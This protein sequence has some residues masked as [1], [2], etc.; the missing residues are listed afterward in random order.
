MVSASTALIPYTNV[1]V[2]GIYRGLV[3]DTNAGPVTGGLFTGDSGSGNRIELQAGA[4]FAYGVFSVKPVFRMRAPIED[5]TGSRSI[6]SGSPFY[7]G[8][9]NRRAMEAEAV[10]TYDPE[11]ATYFFDWDNSDKEGSK[12]AFSLSVLYTFFADKTDLLPYK[13]SDGG[14]IQR[15]DGTWAT[16]DRWA[17]YNSMPLQNNLWQVGA[18]LVG[19]PTNNI[20]L[21]ASVN[22][23][24]LAPS[25]AYYGDPDDITF[26][27]TNLAVRYKKFIASG[28]LLVNGWGSEGWMRDQNWTYPLQYAL[29]FAYGFKK[30]SF[31]DSKNRIGLRMVG[32]TYNNYSQDAYGALP[33]AYH[34]PNASLEGAKYMEVTA[35][36]NI[37][38]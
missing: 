27:G 36:L 1:Y 33:Y 37:G 7:V 30:P 23:G 24:H 10:F 13:T 35:Y 4:D 21:I 20:R 18:R 11:G 26:V 29:D 8:Q 15:N 38:L 2:N 14:Q 25:V 16:G 3:A 31:L 5:A 28:S 9:G 34:K 12:I 32:R 19:N 17:A 22:A 6:L